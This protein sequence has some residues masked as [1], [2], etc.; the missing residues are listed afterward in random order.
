VGCGGGG[1]CNGAGTRGALGLAEGLKTNDSLAL[2]DV[3]HNTVHEEGGEA[4][5]VRVAHTAAETPPG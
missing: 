5:L 2:I 3:D 4:I 1:S